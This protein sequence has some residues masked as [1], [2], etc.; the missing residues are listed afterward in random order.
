MWIHHSTLFMDDQFSEH[1]SQI[2]VVS[3]MTAWELEYDSKPELLEKNVIIIFLM[4]K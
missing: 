1:I 2:T 4:V 3:V